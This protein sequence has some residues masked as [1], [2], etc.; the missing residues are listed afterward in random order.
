MSVDDDPGGSALVVFGVGN[1][2]NPCELRVLSA[3]GD[4][5][6]VAV[7]DDEGLALADDGSRGG[8]CG[9]GHPITLDM[10]L[11]KVRELPRARP[12]VFVVVGIACTMAATAATDAMRT[13]L[14]DT[15]RRMARRGRRQV[16]EDSGSTFT[17]MPCG[18]GVG[19]VIRMD[20][21]VSCG[22]SAER[23]RSGIT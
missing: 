13:S 4:V 18:D 21:A 14:A 11:P 7:D 12:P 20:G 22:G 1:E 16:G 9:V 3:G 19:G 8:T 6:G 2:S 5:G 23:G 15:L 10:S 17:S